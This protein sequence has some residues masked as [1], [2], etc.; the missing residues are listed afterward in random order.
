MARVVVMAS[1]LVLA[2]AW[3]LDGS[4]RARVA[5]QPLRA[6]QLFDEFGDAVGRDGDWWQS[7][8]DPAE[9][10]SEERAAERQWRQQQR[11]DWTGMLNQPK[12]S[13]GRRLRGPAL[14]LRNL[15]DVIVWYDLDLDGDGS[16]DER[17]ASSAA[18]DQSRARREDVLGFE[19]SRPPRASPSRTLDGI[20][21]VGWRAASWQEQGPETVEQEWSQGEQWE[22]AAVNQA[23]EE[24]WAQAQQW[25][26]AAVDAAKEQEWVQAQPW[27]AAP[28]AARSGRAGLADALEENVAVVQEQVEALSESLE[29]V[30]EQLAVLSVT[31][32]VWRRRLAAQKSE[33]SGNIARR[34]LLEVQEQQRQ[35]EAAL[36]VL[37]SQLEER[38]ALLE[39]LNRRRKALV[40]ELG[41]STTPDFDLA[42]GAAAGQQ[43]QQLQSPQQEEM[44]LGQPQ[45]AQVVM[46]LSDPTEDQPSPDINVAARVGGAAARPAPAAVAASFAGGGTEAFTMDAVTG[47][48]AAEFAEVAAP[49]LGASSMP[50]D[51]DSSGDEAASPAAGAPPLR[52][53][54]SNEEKASPAAEDPLPPLS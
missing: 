6:R 9:E 22:A 32:A 5:P 49:D 13:E 26:A 2:A 52:F 27:T 23:A 18:R 46:T 54:S 8:D 37:E 51:V 12:Y 36:D 50:N 53:D 11:Q 45:K 31:A 47:A 1:T 43:Q 42:G 39:E 24:E 44:Y 3:Q 40:L 38:T 4:L 20:G 41:A 30:E 29:R 15:F 14:W 17:A 35:G 19:R 7:Y 48:D 10:W 25:E 16:Q 33:K 28:R 21:E 34:R